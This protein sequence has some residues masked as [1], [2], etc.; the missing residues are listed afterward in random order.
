MAYLLS[1][2]ANGLWLEIPVEKPEIRDVSELPGLV[3]DALE[4]ALEEERVLDED[5]SLTDDARDMLNKWIR[6]LND[7]GF[8]MPTGCSLSE[9]VFNLNEANVFELLTEKE[10]FPMKLEEIPDEEGPELN[11]YDLT[12][13]LTQKEADWM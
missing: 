1:A 6:N 7:A 2:E 3:E 4:K 10:S 5:G 8:G 12:D 13:G 9:I 11:W